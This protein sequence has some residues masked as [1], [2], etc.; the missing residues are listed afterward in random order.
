[1]RKN[2]KMI[3]SH[4]RK[5]VMK[6]HVLAHSIS[7]VSKKFQIQNVNKKNGKRQQENLH[8]HGQR[9]RGAPKRWIILPAVYW[10]LP[11]V[12][13]F[14]PTE[15]IHSGIIAVPFNDIYVRMFRFCTNT[16][17][18][19]C[20]VDWFV[21]GRTT[22]AFITNKHTQPQF[23]ILRNSWQDRKKFILGRS[24]IYSSIH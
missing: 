20:P 1:M 17:G 3:I 16:Q 8:R 14:F 15:C 13:F 24:A 22:R 4:A 2:K 12:T 23:N 18:Y 21:T 5:R 7:S 10:F 9:S 11:F 6:S 19:Y